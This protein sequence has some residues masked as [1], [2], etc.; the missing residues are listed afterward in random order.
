[1]SQSE[2]PGLVAVGAQALAEGHQVGELPVAAAVRHAAPRA[3][4]VPAVVRLGADDAGVGPAV[5]GTDGQ[6]KAWSS[7]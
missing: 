2:A 5:L 4:V 6:D 3:S 1:M 7:E